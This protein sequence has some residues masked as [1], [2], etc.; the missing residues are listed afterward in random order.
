[1]KKMKIER[2][3]VVG[4]ILDYIKSNITQGIWKPGDRISSELELVSELQV[5]R[6]S[7]HNA[8]Q[9]LIAIGVLESF[10]GKGTFVKSMPTEEIQSRMRSI[11]ENRTMNKLIEFRMIVEVECCRRIASKISEN[12][13][14]E[15]AAC[16][17]GMK[18][19]RHESKKF[20]K[21]DIQFHR[22]LLLATQNEVIVQSIDLIREEIQRQSLIYM[23]AE[24]IEKAINYHEQI[25]NCLRIRDGEGAA[26]SMLAHLET[27][28]QGLKQ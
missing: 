19:S 11:T 16:L 8:I 20:V 22:A 25:V 17:E 1:M 4:Q 15:M 23:T 10:Q 24:S 6:A 5:S 14:E 12:T 3:N 28:G 13:I 26:K 21:Y 18:N 7:I 9:Q 27:T 2:T